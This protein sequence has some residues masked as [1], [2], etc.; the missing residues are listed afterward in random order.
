M[1]VAASQDHTIALQPACQN[2]TSSQTTA[3][4]D[5]VIF[6]INKVLVQLMVEFFYKNYHSQSLI[7]YNYVS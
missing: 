5:T 3:K 2:E 1:E 7:L 4:K 6:I